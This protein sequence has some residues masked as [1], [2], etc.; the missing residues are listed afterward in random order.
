[1]W[2][3]D[4]GILEK[5]KFDTQK[6]RVLIPLPRVWKEEPLNFYMLGIIMIVQFLGTI[7][8]IFVFLFELIKKTGLSQSQSSDGEEQEEEGTEDGNRDLRNIEGVG[9]VA[10]EI[11]RIEVLEEV[12]MHA[13]NV[14]F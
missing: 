11:E 12:T 5:I 7:L 13:P 3:R 14:T 4:C 1:M 9:K 10:E 6:Q 2:L 8:S